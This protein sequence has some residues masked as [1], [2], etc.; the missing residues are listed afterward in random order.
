MDSSQVTQISQS[1]NSTNSMPYD[2]VVNSTS[3]PVAETSSR[4]ISMLD[5]IGKK[6]SS[7]KEY[8]CTR[9]AAIRERIIISRIK[10]NKNITTKNNCFVK[11]WRGVNVYHWA[12]K[13]EAFITNEMK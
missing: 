9:P 2:N 13:R 8:L 10:V 5:S 3:S 11:K 6:L 7:A 4:K 12:Q 1:M